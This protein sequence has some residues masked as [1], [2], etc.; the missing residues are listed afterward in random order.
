MSSAQV[1]D[2]LPKI[3]D[4]LTLSE[5]DEILNQEPTPS[6]PTPVIMDVDPHRSTPRQDSLPPNLSG[7][8]RK[9]ARDKANKLARKSALALAQGGV[10]QP[11]NARA[12]P[13][14]AGEQVAGG[15]STSTTVEA[16]ATA[17]CDP[18]K[19][20]SSGTQAGKTPA[21]PRV[22]KNGGKVRPN[23][24]TT[25]GDLHKNANPGPSAPKKKRPAK[26]LTAADVVK[27]SRFWRSVARQDGAKSPEDSL[28]IF[29]AQL[30]KLLEAEM[31]ASSTSPPCFEGVRLM[32]GAFLV[33]CA[34]EES[35]A[36]L[37]SHT[38]TLGTML[39][40]PVSV[41]PPLAGMLPTPRYVLELFL[42]KD[43]EPP[44]NLLKWLA[45]QNPGL[46]TVDWTETDRLTLERSLRISFLVDEKS[47]TFIQSKHQKLFLGLKSVRAILPSAR[48][49]TSSTK[50]PARTTSEPAGP[51]PKS[52]RKPRNRAAKRPHKPLEVPGGPVVGQNPP[53]PMETNETVK[54][55]TSPTQG[56][57]SIHPSLVPNP[58]FMMSTESPPMSM[59][60]LSNADPRAAP[61]GV[62]LDGVQHR[63]QRA[64]GAADV[65]ASTNS[66]IAA[67][68]FQV[69]PVLM[70]GTFSDAAA[71]QGMKF[72]FGTAVS[73]QPLPPRGDSGPNLP[74]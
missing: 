41:G 11:V 9:R 35:A 63:L 44:E 73:P 66:P 21:K 52:S 10:M 48:K 47:R 54:V 7:K 42:D 38:T 53:T 22:P 4:D 33:M 18:P 45:W 36:W 55:A 1:S 12:S 68:S 72:A 37:S 5:E 23:P 8:A 24:P 74:Q 28:P 20:G 32:D 58:N 6:V 27:M 60:N 70:P 29:E 17:A 46:L 69:P 30:N 56:L 25:P 57:G 64:Q 16:P 13:A 62:A 65:W 39:E 3:E 31:L 67:T 34:T 14:D 51:K 26:D 43:R 71:L 2:P 19:A 61:L 40:T 15:R 59:M 49:E 50:T